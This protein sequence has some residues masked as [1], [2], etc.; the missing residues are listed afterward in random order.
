MIGKSARNPLGCIGCARR[1]P[2][3]SP[4]FNQSVKKNWRGAIIADRLW[5]KKKSGPGGVGQ[6]LA[7]GRPPIGAVGSC[8]SARQTP[9]FVAWCK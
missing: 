4:G 3:R 5:V 1:L 2:T 7:T 9:P 8:F 6:Q